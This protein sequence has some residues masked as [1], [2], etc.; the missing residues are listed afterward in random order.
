MLIEKEVIR[1][2]TYWAPDRKT[3]V[4]RKIVVTSEHLTHWHEQGNKMLAMGL[5]VPV[6]CEHDF[7][8]HPMTPA[9]KLKNNAGWVKEFRV[10]DNALF[11]VLDIQDDAIAAKLP[12]T[13]R[14]TSPWFASFVDGKG[15]DWKNVVSHVALTTRPRATEQAQFA[16][17]A[18]ALS[19]AQ[20]AELD[21]TILSRAGRLTAEGQPEFPIAFSMYCTGVALSEE[22]DE[23]PGE[24]KPG[25]EKPKH[26]SKFAEVEDVSME[27]LIADLLSALGINLEANVGDAGFKRA[28]YNAAMQKIHEL[29][30]KPAV[31]AV[32]PGK[33]PGKQNPIVQEQQPMYMSLE[34][35]NK[36]PDEITKGI[37]LSMY[38]ENVKLQTQLDAQ[39][40]VTNSLRDSK[41]T[42]EQ[43]KRKA[44]IERLSRMSPRVKADLEAM[45]A[46][47][48]MALSM[49]DGGTVVDPMGA[50]LT[51]LEKGLVDVPEL[52]KGDQALLSLVPHPTDAEMSAEQS[53]TLA[54]GLARQMGCA[55]EK[56]AG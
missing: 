16:D 33:P 28:L 38:N 26:A 32:P 5:T 15:N 12:K 49:G 48:E 51:V 56:K 37:A 52:L 18:S 35:I 53:D 42:D 29:S 21:D 25:E 1:P 44:R 8:A 50:T 31:P 7:D 13:I 45:V 55:P 22:E 20:E 43:A 14:W 3:G 10:R 17:T 9:E 23:K 27:E 24:E 30:R 46:A 19:I 54:D 34:D 11:S 6:P 36:I 40:K 47:P 39:S 2:G 41:L 4:P